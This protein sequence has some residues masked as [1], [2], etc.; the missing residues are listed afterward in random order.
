MSVRRLRNCHEEVGEE[1]VA[2][3]LSK[4]CKKM[5]TSGYSE[6]FRR[7]IVDAG[8]KAY[9]EQVR[10]E[11]TGGRRRYRTRDCDREERQK[12]KKNDR[13]SWWRKQSRSGDVPITFMKVPYTHNSGLKKTMERITREN[14][15]SVKFVETSGY[16]LQNI[17]EK[18]DPF[19][20][21][22]CGRDD[23]FPGR[24][25]TCGN[26]EGR[27]G[28]YCVTCEEPGCKERGVRYDGE[29]GKNCYSRGLDHIQ[30]YKN[31]SAGNVLWKHASMEHGGRSDV[32]YKMTVLKTY[33]KDN[34]GR[35][36]NEAIRITNNPGVKLNSKADFSQPSLPRL[37]V[38]P[39]RNM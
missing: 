13:Y 29:S 25:G 20:G 14:G 38:L 11:E 36:A 30:G 24:S 28:A 35:K 18:S 5:K 9:E 7:Q 10:V 8:V 12:K 4:Y 16:S 3:I 17:L 37:V 1:E 6:K 39:G 15:L 34:L 27:G 23:C 2:E 19:K 26:C 33:G 31:K 22:T 21:P 32:N